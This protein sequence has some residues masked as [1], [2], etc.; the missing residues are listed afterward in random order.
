MDDAPTPDF[1]AAHSMD[2]AWFAVD[3]DGKVGRFDTG[4]DGAIPNAAAGAGGNL[5]PD[6]D[7]LLV[8]GLLAGLALRDQL[9][10]APETPEEEGAPG[11]PPPPA[12]KRHDERVV[13][14]GTPSL[15]AAD[16]YRDA[17]RP[18]LR[19]EA[20]FRDGELV[21]V[22]ASNPRV[23][24]SRDKLTPARVD[25][26]REFS[27]ATVLVQSDLYYVLHEGERAE[28]PPAGVYEYH[29][30]FEGRGSGT[31]ERSSAPGE[32]L[33]L[34]DVHPSV[35]ERLASLRLPVRFAEAEVVELADH[36]KEGD[37]QTWGTPLDPANAPP[38]PPRAVVTASPARAVGVLAAA[39]IFLLVVIAIV[40]SK[41]LP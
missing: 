5:E 20:T 6:F 17:A 31:Y 38:P 10:Q 27:D 7:L 34:D 33:S 29:H 39:L 25:A 24:V 8:E 30:Q 4:E 32:P 35:R 14:I 41:K 1:P 9:V 12:P 23:L 2:S 11:A 19:A 26:L 3:A 28:A 13:I 40:L 37:V 21:V 18:A 16:G 22:K 36:M 15:D